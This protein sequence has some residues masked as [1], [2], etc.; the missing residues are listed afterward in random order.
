[1]IDTADVRVRY[2]NAG[3]PPALIVTADEAIELGPTGPLV[4]L[5]APGWMTVEARVGPG[6]L[7]ELLHGARCD[8]A[9]AVVKRCMDEVELFSPGGLRDDATIVVLC[10]SE[11]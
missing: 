7:V 10:R 6:R 3:H 5:L 11:H 8:Q 2:A 4:G 9:P 1:V